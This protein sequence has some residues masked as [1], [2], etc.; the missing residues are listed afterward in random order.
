MLVVNIECSKPFWKNIKQDEIE[1]CLSI[2]RGIMNK[3]E[4]KA[5]PFGFISNFFA[6]G[7]GIIDKK[8][9]PGCGGTHYYSILDLLGSAEYSLN[10]P[11]EK[12]LSNLLRANIENTTYIIITPRLLDSYVDLINSLG[13]KFMKTIL[14]SFKENNFQNLNNNIISFIGKEE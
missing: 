10:S 7:Y 14:I 13:K 4:D 6:N 5:I 9:E 11:F 2:T 1:K 12:T 3:L 8:I